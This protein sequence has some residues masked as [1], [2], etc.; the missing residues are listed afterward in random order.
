ML[1]RVRG[2]IG[3]ASEDSLVLAMM[4]WFWISGVFSQAYDIQKAVEL[5]S[6]DASDGA[7][8]STHVSSS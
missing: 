7:G 8:A 1:W 5:F 4:M 3:Y 2:R 6:L